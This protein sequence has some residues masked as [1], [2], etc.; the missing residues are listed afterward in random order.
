[1]PGP[2]HAFVTEQGGE[3]FARAVLAA[4][5]AATPGCTSPVDWYEEWKLIRVED[6]PESSVQVIAVTEARDVEQMV[7]T[8]VA[9]ILEKAIPKF[10]GQRWADLHVVVLD[11]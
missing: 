6:G 2:E 3:E 9:A 8:A 1:D 4:C 11:R 5:E 7:E 10:I